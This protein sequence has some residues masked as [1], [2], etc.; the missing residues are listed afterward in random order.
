MF[1]KKDTQIP[2]LHAYRFDEGELASE[3]EGGGCRHRGQ[4]RHFRDVRV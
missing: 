4:T 1:M 2:S 3:V